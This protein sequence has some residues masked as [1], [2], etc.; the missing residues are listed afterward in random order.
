[1]H[2]PNSYDYSFLHIFFFK[3]NEY[4][5]I[6]TAGSNSFSLRGP[7]FLYSVQH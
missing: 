1:M 6:A 4:E 2:I 7:E 3:V 5:N